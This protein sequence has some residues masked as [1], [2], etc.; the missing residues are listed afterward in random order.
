LSAFASLPRGPAPGLIPTLNRKGFMSAHLDACSRAFVDHAAT[1]GG[2]A[3]DIGCA[4]GIATLAAL[5]KGA[6]VLACDMEPGHLDVLT[7][8][9]PPADRARLR[10]QVGL[11]PE[12]DFPDAGFTSILCSRALH[13]LF[14]ADIE[15]SVAKFRRWLAPG[16]RLFLITDTP[17]A[18]Y[19]KAHAPIYE[20][21]K[22]DGD[23][24]PGFIADT[25]I[26]LGATGRPASFLNPC[27]PDILARVCTNADLIVESAAFIARNDGSGKPVDASSREHAAVVARKPG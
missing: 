18:G 11:L 13:F 7:Q 2:E 9:T 27:D 21:K 22:R 25:S 3:L 14:G 15:V 12:V 23:P 26:Y 5:A 6:R 19:W 24:W 1:A 20:Q 8:Q 10:T 17:Y 16:G 4:Y